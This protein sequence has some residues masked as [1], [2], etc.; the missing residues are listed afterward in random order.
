MKAAQLTLLMTFWSLT[1]WARPGHC[2]AKAWEAQRAPVVFAARRLGEALRTEVAY[3][4]GIRGRWLSRTPPLAETV[5]S[6]VTA[7]F[8]LGFAQKGSGAF[9]GNTYQLQRLYLCTF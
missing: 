4:T 1:T 9:W 8:L 2:V 3:G 5:R 7:V 6:K